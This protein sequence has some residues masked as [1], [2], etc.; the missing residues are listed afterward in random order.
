MRTVLDEVVLGQ[1][2]ETARVG[3]ALCHHQ[4]GR[5][6]EFLALDIGPAVGVLE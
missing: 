1:G 5:D 6:S 3:K 4:R 2:E